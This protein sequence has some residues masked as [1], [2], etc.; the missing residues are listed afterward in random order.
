[1]VPRQDLEERVR[2]LGYE[3]LGGIATRVYRGRERNEVLKLA[4]DGREEERE[5]VFQ[6]FRRCLAAS[7][8]Y[9]AEG[10][11]P[12]VLAVGSDFEGSG[13]PY[14]RER[15]VPGK[16]LAEAYLAD[17]VSW[18]ALLP[19]VL[20]RIYR[21]FLAG[22]VRDV[23][24]AWDDNL[25]WHDA[26]RESEAFPRFATLHARV[27]EAGERL[28]EAA[29]C[30][31]LIHGDLQLGNILALTGERAGEVM[32]IDWQES[33]YWPIAFDFTMLY[34]FLQG[35]VEQ[36]EPHLQPFYEGQPPL[37]RL[38]ETLAARLPA[39]LGIGGELGDFTL[40]RMGR[41]W[42]YKLDQAL[43]AGDEAAATRWER[44]VTDLVEGRMYR[45][46]PLPGQR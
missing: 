41:G 11:M 35:P 9:A 1:M 27:R 39:E 19:E 7:R 2:G 32:L 37:R 6:S 46:W 21:R 23:T 14:L 40:F 8:V 33:G 3:P 30:G 24:P 22:P 4:R 5:E 36:V 28:R 26:L 31:P 20:I 17:P 42:L 16:N 38:W 13:C 25:R 34:T 12:E 43:R 10:L 18:D 15:Y 29:P 44:S 45:E